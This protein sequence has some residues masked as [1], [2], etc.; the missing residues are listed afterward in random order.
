MPNTKPLNIFFLGLSGS[1]K[2]TQ[3]HMLK[4]ALE[5]LYPTHLISTGDLFRELLQ[6]DTDAA[7]H[8]KTTLDKG[9]RMPNAFALSMWVHEVMWRV[10]EEEGIVFESSPR[11]Q[12]EAEVGLEVMKYLEREKDTKAIYLP[13]SEEEVIERLLKR[14]RADDNESAIKERIAF[15]HKNVIPAVEYFRKEGMLIEVDGTGDVDKIHAD[16]VKALGLE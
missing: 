16:I 1:G 14:G 2:G 12:W 4:D 11:S 8:T 15:F 13:L 5:N 7:K 9:E 3:A 10:H 6:L